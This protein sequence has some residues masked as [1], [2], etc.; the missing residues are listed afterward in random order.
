[1]NFLERYYPLILAIISIVVI[2]FF[3]NYITDF[4]ILL[5]NIIQSSLTI[6]GTLLGFLLTILTIINTISTRRM[7][8]VKDAGKYPTLVSFLNQAIFANISIIIFCFLFFFLDSNKINVASIKVI[9]YCF[10][11]IAILNILLTVR[12]AIIFISLMKDKTPKDEEK[13]S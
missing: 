11:F 6:A 8:F 13:S 3:Q 1:M 2:Y 4:S 7:Q 12:F 10:I 9:D 5:P